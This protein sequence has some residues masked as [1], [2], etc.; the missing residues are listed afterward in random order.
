[1]TNEEAIKE[2][3]EI[4]PALDHV[5][6]FSG[7]KKA[8]AIDLAIKA[9]SWPSVLVFAEKCGEEREA[10]IAELNRLMEN[11]IPKIEPAEFLKE[12]GEA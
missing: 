10:L 5:F 3:E 1:M 11:H 2:L 9:L 6:T 7:A 12:G 8:E 4:K